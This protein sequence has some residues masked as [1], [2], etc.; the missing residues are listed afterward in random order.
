M[1]SKVF[2]KASVEHDLKKIDRPLVEHILS[3]LEQVLSA[4]PRAGKPL[5]GELEGLMSYR[6]GDYRI[7]YSVIAGGVLILR[8][9]HRREAYR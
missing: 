9:R 1:A 3:K 2:Y 7:R 6:V 8:I 5:H 4:H